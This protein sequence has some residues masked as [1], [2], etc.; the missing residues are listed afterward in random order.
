MNL[1]QSL[2]E[3]IVPKAK[4]GL[5]KF[6]GLIGNNEFYIKHIHKFLKASNIKALLVKIDSPGGLPG[7]SQALFN[8]LKKFREKKPIVVMI[9]DICASGAYY[10]AA[11][12]SHIIANPSS[13]IGSIGVMFGIH[14]MPMP[15]LEKLME[16][17]KI[18]FEF[19][20]SGKYKSAGNFFKKNSEE[21]LGIL[22]GVSD[23]TY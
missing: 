19:I 20:Q 21:E 3:L 22:Q 5:L 10:I 7:S 9:D 17:W 11:A 4:V 8:E 15:N 23:D 18:K 6:S 16:D 1:T 2:R 14:G 12:G 13:M